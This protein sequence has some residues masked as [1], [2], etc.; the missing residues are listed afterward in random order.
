LAAS[1]SRQIGIEDNRTRLENQSILFG[2][3]RDVQKP[4]L[5]T[6]EFRIEDVLV[7]ISAERLSAVTATGLA[8]ASL[9]LTSEDR[10]SQ[11]RV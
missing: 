11:H 5:E 8:G 4:P 3:H 7:E 1:A 6:N 10:L 9:W 2:A